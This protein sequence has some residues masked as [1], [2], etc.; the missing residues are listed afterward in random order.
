[1]KRL[2]IYT[3][4]AGTMLASSCQKD[5]IN[6]VPSAQLSDV[7][8]FDTK[9]RI[10]SQV[11]GLYSVA[12]NGNFFGERYE[13]Y[14]DVRGEE[15]INQQQNAFTAYQTWNFTVI[16]NSQEV[17]NLWNQ[18]YITINNINVFLDGLAASGTKVI[19]EATA[20][21]YIGEAKF[22]RG[23]SYYSLSQLY[24]R[25]YWDN[26]STNL[27][28]VVYTEGH[29]SPQAYQKARSTVEE[30]YKQVI[31][32]LDSAETLLPDTYD[33]AT[34]NVTH[35]HK[36]AAIALKTRVYLS[37]GAYDKVITEANKIVPLTAP[38]VAP[39]GV[40]NALAD[41]ISDV[42]T[43]Y[44]TT[45]S[46][47]SFPFTSASGDDPNSQNSFGEY[48]LPGALGGKNEY[49][50]NPA[51]IIANTTWTTTDDRRKFIYTADG[52]PYL[53][54]FATPDPFT[55]WNPVLRY[56]EVLLNL[57]EAL[58][59]QTNAVDPRAVALLNA[60][61]N[62]SDKATT[63]TVASFATVTDLINAVLLERRIELL[64]E[65]FRGADITRLGLP[66]PVKGGAG[67]VQPTDKKYIW[68]ISTSELTYNK[69]AKDN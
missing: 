66:F 47:F 42:F 41:K 38:F 27:G 54:K 34:L 48:Y 19:D 63:F 10:V 45:E 30:T 22:L 23:L 37:M 13:I 44:T 9:E 58:A 20:D 40:P 28:L 51:G 21:N 16:G 26:P 32:D 35:A 12:K 4:L 62:R 18:G 61:R 46:I 36:N 14:N 11:N 55:D 59:H 53:T 60:V 3:L 64:G 15:F 17:Q 67:A 6:P 65:G 2:S 33:D 56:S 52:T 25:P 24:T 7:S 39:S 29:K 50:L 69:L 43:S 1:M 8:A 31:T 49:S 68:P 5:L 57:A